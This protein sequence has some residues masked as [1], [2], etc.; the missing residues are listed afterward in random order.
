MTRKL[1]TLISACLLT[2]AICATA[3]AQTRATLRGSVNDEVGAVIVGATVTLT[4]ASGGAPKTAQS[5]A[6][7]GYVFNG[8]TPGKYMIH[9][10]AAGFSASEPVEVEVTTARRDPLTL[11]LKVAEIESEVSVAADT[12]I[13]TDAANNAN[14]QVISG[15]DLEALPDDPDELAAALQAL[16]GPSIGPGGGQIFIDGF[17]GANMPP[18]ES[19]REIRINQNP[20]AAENDQPSGRVDILTRPGTDKF[21]GGAN[22]SFTDESL[23]S[24]NPFAVSSSKRAPYQIR[25]YG[26]NVSGP[27]IKNKMSFFFDINRNEE[28]D[29]D[30]IRATV[31]NVS[32]PNFAPTEFGIAILSPRDRTNLGIRLEYA[33]NERNTLIGRYNF[34][35]SVS[36]NLGLGN[37]FSLPVRAYDGENTNHNVQL[38]ETA[39]LNATTINETR[40]QFSRSRNQSFGNNT[41]PVLTVSSAFGGCAI[42]DASCSQIGLASNERTSWELNNFTQMQ[43]GLHT[44]KFG[45]RVRNVNIDDI[46]PNNFGG[47]WSFTGGFG[48]EFDAANNP[49]A[50]TNTFLT[51][52]ERYRRTALI[53]AQG[54]TAQQQAYCGAATAA[55]C[56]RILGGGA[57]QFGI[58][59][60]NPLASVSQTDLAVYVQDDWRIRP[61]FTL[62]YG[63]RYEYQTNADSRF[64][65]APRLGFA[66][67]PGGGAQSTRPPQMVIRGGI[68]VFYNRFSEGQ[69]LFAN[70]FNGTNQIQYAVPEFIFRNPDGSGRPPTAAEQAANPAFGL[71]NNFPVVPTTAQLAIVPATQQTIYRVDPNLQTP[72]LY[73]MGLQVERQLPRNM[74]MFLGAYTMR[75]THGIRLRDINAP[76][77]PNFTTRPTPGVG[78]IYQYEG[79]GKFRMSQMFIGFNSRLNPRLSLNGSY[80]LSKAQGDMDGFGATGL[81]MNSYDLSTEFGRT[82]GDVRHR[83]T[84]I[85]TITPGWWGI[86]FNPFIIANTGPPFN[87]TTGQDLNLDRAFNERPTFAQLNAF[88]TENASRCTAFDYTRTDNVFIPRNYGQSPGSVV[89]NLNVSRTFTFGGESAPRGSAGGGGGQRGGGGRSG[90]SMPG[91]GGQR[92]P[93]GGGPPGGGMMVGGPGGGGAPGRYSL[94]VSVSIQNLFN[95]VNLRQPEGN[96]SSPNFGQSLGL[97]FF[98]G[99]GGFGGGGSGAGNRRVTLN[100]RFNF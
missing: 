27:I 45:G 40:F 74:T 66:W 87:I 67:S 91:G 3:S 52:I 55:Q 18:K 64:N 69:T 12:P 89:V 14:Q 54:L 30:L 68:G 77:P 65:F 53:S 92:G 50:G 58:N 46:S 83:F 82:S 93:G 19:I 90:P 15:K 32:D 61:N 5:G 33:I 85:G 97:S 63:L 29:N 60:G 31:L 1:L 6:D 56:I 57:S 75:M 39:V 96:I 42:P 34:N 38:T 95:H 71:L 81:P 73:L 28:E 4:D 21:R 76:L 13:N 7:G 98:G 26:G 86:V 84:L 23:N 8:L 79:S 36:E 17:S 59:T 80:N 22:F 62:S 11:T 99:F 43:R 48:P 47:S 78:D 70:R 44:V 49:L 10:E 100:L 51:S 94:N 2:V 9:A 41:I 24:R 25:R 88:C 20:F 35:R 37:G 72:N 16:A